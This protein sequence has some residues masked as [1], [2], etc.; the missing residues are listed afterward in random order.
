MNLFQNYF[1]LIFENLKFNAPDG[2]VQ[3]HFV[4]NTKLQNNI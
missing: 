3:S 1:D 2:K 4:N